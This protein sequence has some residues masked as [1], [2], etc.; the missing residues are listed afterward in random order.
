VLVLASCIFDKLDFADALDGTFMVGV[1]GDVSI[2]HGAGWFSLV[3]VGIKI[4]DNY[5]RGGNSI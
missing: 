5:R 2:P 1:S 4:I 3:P